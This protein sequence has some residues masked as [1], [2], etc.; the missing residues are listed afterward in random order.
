MVLSFHLVKYCVHDMQPLL[1]RLVAKFLPGCIDA[2]WT[3]PKMAYVYHF[4]EPSRE[5]LGRLLA[6]APDGTAVAVAAWQDRLAILSVAQQDSTVSSTDSGALDC[7][8][9]VSSC[10]VADTSSTSTASMSY[11]EEFGCVSRPCVT[12]C[13][14]GVIV[15]PPVVYTEQEAPEVA[16]AQ[17]L[18]VSSS[19]L[20][21]IWD[22]AFLAASPGSS[23]LRLAALTHR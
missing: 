13:Q 22:L 17:P 7:S 11:A 2:H 18:E 21:T 1:P 4:A 10:P 9:A 3:Q 19:G 15:G 12:Q 20:G 6:V 23:G 16:G 5:C 8:P 14:R